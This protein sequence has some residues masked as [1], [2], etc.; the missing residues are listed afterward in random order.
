MR[1][2]K[3]TELPP[4]AKPHPRITWRSQGG[5]LRAYAYLKDLGGGREALIVDGENYGTTDPVIAETLLARRMAELL[6]QRRTKVLLRLDPDADLATFCIYH[7]EEKDE[8]YRE[9]SREEEDFERSTWADQWL[10]ISE[11]YLTRAVAFFTIHQHAVDGEDPEPQPRN[12]A[13]ISVLDVRAYLRWLKAQPNGRGGF[14]GRNSRRLHLS[15]LSGVFDRAISEGRLEQG[16]NPVAALI[17]KPTSPRSKTRWLEV[18]ELALLLESARTVH[19]FGSAVGSRPLPCI[20]ELLAT[21]LLTG[22][23]EDEIR[24]LRIRHLNFANDE[25]SI[26]GTKTR[27]ADRIIPMHPQLREILEPY[28]EKL[29]RRPSDLLFTNGEGEAFGDWRKTLDVIA[30]RAGFTAKQIRTR[31]FRT[32]YIT[33]RLACI[34]QGA[35][36]EPYKVAREV[37]HKSMNTTLWIY[38][39][40]QRRRVRMEEM[41]YRTS[42]INPDLRDRLQGLY[43]HPVSPEKPGARESAELVTRFLAATAGKRTAE[44]VTATG[45]SKATVKRLRAGGF[46]TL[47]QNTKAKLLAYLEPG[48]DEHAAQRQPRV[49]PR[50]GSRLRAQATT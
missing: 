17:G 12:L 10:G 43:V 30:V 13:A 35:F 32:S 40:T 19:D 50:I 23:R 7:L 45:L 36:I 24:R 11:K 26:P 46:N 33:H 47:Q 48:G 41:A 25:I 6:E 49:K 27:S 29:D 42:A 34:D 16:S 4:G 5:Q 44:I 8:E 39:R 14:L 21:F 3:R 28:V 1:P 20:Y 15:V 38:G 31:V 2:K 22:A 18:D 37:G 9:R